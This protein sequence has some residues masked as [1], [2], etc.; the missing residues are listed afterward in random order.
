PRSRRRLP[1]SSGTASSSSSRPPS[2][3]SPSASC[4]ASRSGG[5]AWRSPS[6]SPP[7]AAPAPTPPSSPSNGPAAPDAC[8]RPSVILGPMVRIGTVVGPVQDTGRATGF[9]TQALGYVRRDAESDVLVPGAGPGPGLVMEA[10][11]QTHLDLYTDSRA[12]Q[13]AEVERLI[14][15]GATR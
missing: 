11:D 12:E 15:L 4:P 10:R 9:W 6:P 14:A 5:P 3:A 8:A 7:T 13:L 2:S 1:P